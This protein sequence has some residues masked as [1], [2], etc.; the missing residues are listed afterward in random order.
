MSNIQPAPQAL[1]TMKITDVLQRWP[2]TADVFHS[3]AMACVGCAVA[4]FYSIQDAAEVYGLVP[5]D[6]IRDLLAAIHAAEKE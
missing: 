2:G 6:F 4:S 1:A 5:E 3:H